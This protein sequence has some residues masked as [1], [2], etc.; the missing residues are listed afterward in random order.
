MPLTMFFGFLGIGSWAN[1]LYFLGVGAKPAEGGPDPVK[2]VGWI[3][4]LTGLGI[5]SQALYWLM[6]KAL[7]DLTIGISGLASAFAFVWMVLGVVQLLGLDLRPVG[8][9]AFWVGSYTVFFIYIT[10]GSLVLWTTMAVWT[11]T[12]FAITAVTHGKLSAKI[13]G[14]LLLVWAVWTTIVPATMINLTGKILF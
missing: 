2:T 6:T 13:L 12:L 11:I 10:R 3:S 5:I 9:M 1:A 7:G 8:H 4:L 14:W